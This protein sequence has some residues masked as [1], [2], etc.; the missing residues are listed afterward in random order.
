MTALLID[1]VSVLL[2]LSL[3][4]QMTQR[5]HALIALSSGRSQKV[6]TGVQNVD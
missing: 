6:G 2:L 3:L 5:R 1:I 4:R